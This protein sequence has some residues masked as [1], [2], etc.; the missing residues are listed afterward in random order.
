VPVGGLSRE[1]LI[2]TLFAD[3]DC[4]VAGVQKTFD[5]GL[6]TDYVLPVH[7]GRDSCTRRST[8]RCSA[9]R[10]MRFAASSSRRGTS[11]SRRGL[12]RQFAVER[13]CNRER[14]F[15]A[16]QRTDQSLRQSWYAAASRTASATP[17]A[18][19]SVLVLNQADYRRALID[20]LFQ[21]TAEVT[22]A[23]TDEIPEKLA[24]VLEVLKAIGHATGLDWS[25][26]EALADHKRQERGC[27]TRRLC[28]DGAATT[29]VE[30]Q[31]PSLWFIPG[32]LDDV[33]A[34]RDLGD[35]VWAEFSRSGGTYNHEDAQI[36][37]RCY[38]HTIQSCHGCDRI[39][40]HVFSW[41]SF[42]NS[43]ADR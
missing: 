29:S 28:L 17:G 4:V 37:F 20:K 16:F 27:F 12:Q 26:I 7:K 38:T 25:T 33:L 23:S 34:D 18:T 9:T 32:W 30:R 39:E 3:V 43:R 10:S 22:E 5:L 40:G 41:A 21:E 6:V 13:T 14:I 19:P 24:D 2:G 42:F 36:Q 35:D 1:D 8:R 11:P 15:H 31:Q